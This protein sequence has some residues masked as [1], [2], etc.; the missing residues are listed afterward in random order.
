MGAL[1]LNSIANVDRFLL[2]M[3]EDASQVIARLEVAKI[4]LQCLFPAR[5]YKYPSI[6]SGWVFKRNPSDSEFINFF[7]FKDTNNNDSLL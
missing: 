2:E 7:N 4:F 6:L 3:D 1:Y 5:P